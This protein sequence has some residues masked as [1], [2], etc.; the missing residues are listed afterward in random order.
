MNRFGRR[1]VGDPGQR[2]FLDQPVLQGAEHALAAPARLRRIGWNMLDPEVLESSPNLRQMLLVDRS[3]RVR[4]VEVVAATIRV[5]ARW[6]TV[7][8]KRLQK[9]T[10]ARCRAF[11]LNQKR[12]VDRARRIVHRDNQVERR[13]SPQASRRASRPGAASCL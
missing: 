3:I 2:E 8:G 11:F 13:L 4:R 5:E 1:N 7:C 12:R 9:P 10:K 6:Q